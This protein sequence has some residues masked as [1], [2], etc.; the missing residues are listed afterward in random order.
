MLGQFTKPD[1]SRYTPNFSKTA[2]NDQIDI[3][4]NEG[5]FPDGR[6]YRIELWAQDGLTCA[7]IFMPTAGIENFSNPQFCELF[8][9]AGLISWQPGVVPSAYALPMTDASGNSCWQVSVTLGCEETLYADAAVSFRAYARGNGLG[10]VLPSP[11]D[12]SGS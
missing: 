2:E 10:G 12:A 3:G 8:Q 5:M 1:R 9:A 7:S 11:A 6:V 4:W